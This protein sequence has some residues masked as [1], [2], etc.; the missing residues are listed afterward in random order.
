MS[1]LWQYDFRAK[2]PLSRAMRTSLD[3]DFEG[4]GVFASRYVHWRHPGALQTLC[5]R[6]PF[7]R[8]QDPTIPLCPECFLARR[9]IEKK[10]AV[11]QT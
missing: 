4:T 9:W 10:A 5:R 3:L 7:K 6:V 2:S 1:R 8:A 11:C